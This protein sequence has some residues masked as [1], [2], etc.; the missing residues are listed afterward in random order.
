MRPW[1]TGLTPEKFWE[2]SEL[3]VGLANSGDRSAFET[4]V[5]A[6]L[7][8]NRRRISAI[9]GGVRRRG[10]AR[11]ESPNAIVSPN[12]EQLAEQ[13]STDNRGSSVGGEG[14]CEI[15]VDPWVPG[16]PE[17]HAVLGTTGEG[18]IEGR[19]AYP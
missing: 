2:N 16:G 8:D 18:M 5:E 4:V 17:V 15:G 3:L 9:G 1:G 6:L 19:K 12:T 13:S 14:G 10:G 11:D 7:T